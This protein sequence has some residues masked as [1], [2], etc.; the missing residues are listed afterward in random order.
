MNSKKTTLEKFREAD[1]IDDL[2]EIL[3]YT[4]RS[5]SYLI[6]ILSPTKKYYSFE[7]KKRNGGMREIL[8]PHL[9]LK[10]LQR[11]LSYRLYECLLD[12]E[13]LKERPNSFSHAFQKGKSITTNARK[14][15]NKRWV[16]NTD[17]E[18]FFGSINF[19]RV[20]GC[21]IKDRS[22]LFKES[23][24][25]LIAQIV[26]FENKLPQGAPTSPII[27][28]IV[29]RS[30]DIKLVGL[31]AKNGCTYTRYADDITFSTNKD[32]FPDQIAISCKA[33][34]N[35]WTASEKLKE[36]ITAS[37]FKENESK[38]RM[39]YKRGKQMV[40]GL[41]VNKRINVPRDYRK[42]VRIMVRAFCRTGFFY[43]PKNLEHRPQNKA[44]GQDLSNPTRILQ[45][46]LGFID[47]IDIFSDKTAL[48]FSEEDYE[49]K[50]KKSFK[51]NELKSQEKLYKQ[52]L[53]HVNF[54]KASSLT[55]ITEGKSDNIHL[56]SAIKS[57][58]HNYPS[59]S[60]KNKDGDNLPLFRI[61]T[62]EPRR[63]NALI[64]LCGGVS[65]MG[66]FARDYSEEKG[67]KF[68]WSLVGTMASPVIMLLD[69]DKG[70]KT[71]QRKCGD[72]Q[73]K[74][75][76]ESLYIVRGNLYIVLTP[77]HG[78]T[79]SSIEDLYHN[80]ILSIEL[81]GKKFDPS[82]E[83]EDTGNH[84]GKMAFA[85]KI[86][87]SAAYNVDFSNF[88]SIFDQFVEVDAH[89]RTQDRRYF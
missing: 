59:L 37:G 60:A 62:C 81:D 79:E 48:Q 71:F 85:E 77:L 87:K 14:H 64:G 39:Q 69:N 36:K 40:T 21:L 19:G 44:K 33:D 6:Y 41:I 49:N 20:R 75:I 18:D 80:D 53:L 56:R 28:N 46:M 22:F 17:L 7:I 5:L 35:N 65:D 26:C 47:T 70:W 4:S 34:S 24:A 1:S 89:W 38:T 86:I 15:R 3:G 51:T 11:I 63:T 83:T 78:K 8:R 27:S 43:L 68:E 16:F 66:N 13:N 32:Q 52:F 74:K 58:G 2:A 10:L 30:L 31:A 57:I 76:N 73:P 84:Y 42:S 9:K 45:G 25:T 54:F 82:N 12:E 29:A 67:M 88:T 55:I 50:K 72:K 61:L 23:I